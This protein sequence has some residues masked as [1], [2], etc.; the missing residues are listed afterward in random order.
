MTST[1]DRR[2]QHAQTEP[3]LQRLFEEHQARE[4]RLEELQAK[5]WLTR[6]EEQEVKRLKKEKLQLKD[7]ME[8][9]RRAHSQ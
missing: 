3:E 6:E 7:Q 4:R 9:F 2:E 8:S 5:G 1:A